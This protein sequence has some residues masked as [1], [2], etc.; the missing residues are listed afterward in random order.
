[1]TFAIKGGVELFRLAKREKEIDQ[2]TIA[3]SVS[4]DH[5]TMRIYD[6]YRVINGRKISYYRHLIHIFDF[7]ALEGKGK[8]TIY[9]F[10]KNIYNVWLPDHFK[11]LCLVIDK[12]QA[13]LSFEILE[14]FDLQFQESGLSQDFQSY[15]LS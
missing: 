10:T 4:H 3:F 14:Q 13:D 2:Q 6:H 8:W 1:M 15:N 5:R 12:M 9:R 11:K 7:T